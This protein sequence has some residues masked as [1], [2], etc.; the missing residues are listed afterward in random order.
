MFGSVSPELFGVTSL[1][2]LRA[3]MRLCEITGFSTWFAVDAKIVI[4]PPHDEGYVGNREITNFTDA[5]R[6]KPE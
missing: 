1:Y 3:S 6:T 2:T 5:I 4:K